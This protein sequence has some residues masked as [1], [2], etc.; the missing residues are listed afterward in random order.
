[1]FIIQKLVTTWTKSSRGGAGAQLR[2]AVPAN[3]PLPAAHSAP[4]LVQ[5]ITFSELVSFAPRETRC[6]AVEA[7]PGADLGVEFENLA[8]NLEVRA[9]WHLSLIH[10]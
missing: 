6:D 9:V 3:F 7:V 4:V 2:A 10:I 8:D 5:E 1:M